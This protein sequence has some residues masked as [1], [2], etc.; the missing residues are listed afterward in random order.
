MLALCASYVGS[1]LLRGL[2]VHLV[3]FLMVLSSTVLGFGVENF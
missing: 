2:S 3:L 1:V